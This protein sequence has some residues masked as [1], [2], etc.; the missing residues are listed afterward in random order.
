MIYDDYVRRLAERASAALSDIDPIGSNLEYGPEF[1]LAVLRWLEGI[2]PSRY[3]VARGY[4]VTHD[5]DKA[6]DDLLIY[7]R[8]NFPWLRGQGEPDPS[9][10]DRIPAEAVYCYIEAKHS[11]IV[12]GVRESGSQTL[13]TALSQVAN[14]KKTLEKRPVPRTPRAPCGG[15]KVATLNAKI[16]HSV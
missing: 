2:L 7:D 1:E 10:K 8:L 4:V 12:E 5:S 14:A 15:R 13:A 9:R 11:L 16:G 6:G 3:G